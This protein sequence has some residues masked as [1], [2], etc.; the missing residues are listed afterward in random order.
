MGGSLGPVRG[1]KGIHDENIA[2]RCQPARQRLIIG[3]LA[4]IKTHVLTEHDLALA[5]FEPIEPIGNETH[6]L[7]QQRA[8]MLRYRRQRENRIK[9][10]LDRS[11][12][13]RHQH[14]PPAGVDTGLDGR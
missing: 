4:R 5:H 11:A 7:T 1:T 9:F 3:L 2:K 14:D 6:W 8:Q 12:K 13:V 10:A